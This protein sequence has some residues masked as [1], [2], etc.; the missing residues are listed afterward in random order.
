M[1]IA[2]INIALIVSW[3][4][5]MLCPPIA[6]GFLLTYLASFVQTLL[7]SV[8]RSRELDTEGLVVDSDR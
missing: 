3:I 1:A 7:T 6:A 2:S 8:T 4:Y 5:P